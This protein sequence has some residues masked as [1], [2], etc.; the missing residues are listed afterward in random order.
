MQIRII[1][2]MRNIFIR[3]QKNPGSG[4]AI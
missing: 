4:L 2:I 1:R 3:K